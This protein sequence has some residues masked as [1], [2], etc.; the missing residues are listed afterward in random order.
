M[1]YGLIVVYGLYFYWLAFPGLKTVIRRL[2][3]DRPTLFAMAGYVKGHLACF[4]P[5]VEGSRSNGR[6]LNEEILATLKQP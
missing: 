3:T 5:A 6:S 1:T 2:T 4:T